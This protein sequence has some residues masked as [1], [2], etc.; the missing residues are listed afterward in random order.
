MKNQTGRD[1][2]IDDDMASGVDVIKVVVPQFTAKARK[3]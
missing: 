3:D 2:E 1:F